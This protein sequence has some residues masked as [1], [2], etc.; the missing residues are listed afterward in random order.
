MENVCL[1]IETSGNYL[2]VSLL[3]FDASGS[4]P[5]VL[6]SVYKQC[7]QRQSDLLVP[8]VADVLAKAKLRKRDIRLVGVD[9]GPGSFTGVRVG[10]TVARTL[11]QGLGIPVV[12]VCS[13]EALAQK[14]LSEDSMTGREIV[15]S[16]L[17][18]L[19]GEIY[20]AVY[21]SRE[22][23]HPPTWAGEREFSGIIRKYRAFKIIHV[24][25]AQPPRPEVIG[26]LAVR[27]YLSA[28]KKDRFHYERAVPLYLQP[29]W[30]EKTREG[31]LK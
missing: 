13:L 21:S 9:V 6:R 17:P 12:G 7:R 23:L 31:I 25:S 24:K 2:G 5:G 16:S 20:F 19:A 27:K 10:V 22:S 14:A 28:D 15:V 3:G 26:R 30:A 1:A 18:A 29:S 11:G 8:S 4:N